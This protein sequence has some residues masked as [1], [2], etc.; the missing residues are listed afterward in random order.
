VN[1]LR[2]DDDNHHHITS[3]R[4][5]R[6]KTQSIF[7]RKRLGKWPVRHVSISFFFFF[8]RVHHHHHS[9]DVI[10]KDTTTCRSLKLLRERVKERER[11]KKS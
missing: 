5:K 2:D 4:W 3:I 11:E 1:T 8:F 7:M 9:V 6:K 10:H